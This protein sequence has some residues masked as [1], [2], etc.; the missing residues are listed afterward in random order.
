MKISINGHGN[1]SLFCFR[2]SGSANVSASPM[3]HALQKYM[4][5]KVF[6]EMAPL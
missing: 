1:L 6:L 3:H 2:A 4:H 5:T